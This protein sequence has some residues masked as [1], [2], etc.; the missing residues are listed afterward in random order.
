MME[1][2]FDDSVVRG[3]RRYARQ[4]SRALGLHGECSY[5]QAEDVASAYIALD[6][7]L[8]RF[9]GRDVALLWNEKHGWSVGIETHSG[10]DLVVVDY[11][12]Q[13]LLPAPEKVAAWAR[14]LF[15]AGCNTDGKGRRPEIPE[16]KDGDNV[17]HRLASL[18]S[19]PAPA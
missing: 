4:V 5:V 14:S 19:A 15:R 7:Q 1:L 6:G 11:L 3:L 2:D 18:A 12:G 10:E 16:L 8:T 13:N 9:P 17:R